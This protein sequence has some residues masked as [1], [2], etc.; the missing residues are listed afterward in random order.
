MAVS[1]N[2]FVLVLLSEGALQFRD[3]LAV[4]EVLRTWDAEPGQT[5]ALLAAISEA[6]P[7]VDDYHTLLPF[8]SECLG[9][10]EDVA[11]ALGVTLDQLAVD[12]GYA[13]E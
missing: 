13:V 5:G 8:I 7:M 10:N 6:R 4:G 12:L 11:T 2:G 9:C 1:E 3:K